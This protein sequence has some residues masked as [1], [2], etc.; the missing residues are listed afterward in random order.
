MNPNIAKMFGNDESMS[1]GHVLANY[2]ISPRA[3]G[4]MVQNA[5]RTMMPSVYIQANY[6]GMHPKITSWGSWN[7]AK[8]SDLNIMFGDLT[9]GNLLYVD[10]PYVASRAYDLAGTK[11]SGGT[12]D[13]KEINRQKASNESDYKCRN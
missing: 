13:L 4:E 10:V 12:G 7:K 8:E 11:G 2:P 5:E 6:M 9:R 3:M 1:I